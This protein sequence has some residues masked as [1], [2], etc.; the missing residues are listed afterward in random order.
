MPLAALLSQQRGISAHIQI[1]FRY[2]WKFTDE[3]CRA[4][5]FPDT[6]KVL[7]QQGLKVGVNLS[8]QIGAQ[9]HKSHVESGP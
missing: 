4:Y 2:L 6:P 1:M 5:T 3:K 8:T 7:Q 9:A